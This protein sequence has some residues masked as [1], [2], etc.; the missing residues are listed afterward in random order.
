MHRVGVMRHFPAVISELG[1]DPD[2]ACARAGV[3]R[4]ALD[5]SD[6]PITLAAMGRLLSAGQEITGCA[7]IGLLVGMHGSLD[8]L[9]LVGAYMAQAP[10]VGT[11][12]HDLTDHQHRYVRGA[13]PYVL[14]MGQEIVFGYRVHETPVAAVEQICEGA[15]A[16]AYNLVRE[17]CG[18]YP[19]EVLFACDEPQDRRPFSRAFGVPL[20]FNAE[21]Y[22]L[23]YP[24]GVLKRPVMGA[25]AARREE[26]RGEVEAY[27]AVD[28][29]DVASRLRR[30]LAVVVLGG[31]QSLKAA[32]EALGLHPRV[33]NRRLNEEGTTFQRELADARF[34][35]AGQ[36]LAE[37]NLSATVIS[38]TLGYADLSVFSRAFERWSGLP[39]TRWRKQAGARE[40]N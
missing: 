10:D 31:D 37:T 21:L 30:H 12:I 38:E 36:L 32:A 4:D 17:L 7:H 16:L 24:I 13:L 18:L 22:G 33:L 39:P 20:R 9:G 35:L 34:T 19:V 3:R 40:A 29:P 6:N 11:A 15:L 23:A 26:L 28:P 1:F 8:C 27:W 25:S 5:N 2:E 14:P